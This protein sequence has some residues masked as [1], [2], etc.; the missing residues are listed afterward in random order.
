MSWI[1]QYGTIRP[2]HEPD[3]LTCMDTGK[4]ASGE[5][6]TADHILTDTVPSKPCPDC[7]SV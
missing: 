6:P 3:C 5:R 2:G 4:V 7:R 1:D